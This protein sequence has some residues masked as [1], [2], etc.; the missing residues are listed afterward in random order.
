[1]TGPRYH[2]VDGGDADDLPGGARYLLA[3]AAAL[4]LAHRLAGAQELAGQVHVDHLLPL[5][6]AHLVQGRVLLDASVVDQDVDGAELLARPVEHGLNVDLAAH[7]R[8]VDRRLRAAAPDLLGDGLGVLGARNIVHHDVGPRVAERDGYSLADAGAGT[9]N[10]GLLAAKHLGDR[11]GGHHRLRKALAN[12]FG[13][14]HRVHDGVRGGLE[15]MGI[16]RAV[17]GFIPQ[18]TTYSG[19]GMTEF[20]LMAAGPP[21]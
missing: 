13:I 2:L 12:E 6:E 3:H 21:E 19:N 5:G 8:A 7:V 18:G 11:A 15:E 9:R 20:P 16:R 14:Y 1:M 4:E 17:S 10:D